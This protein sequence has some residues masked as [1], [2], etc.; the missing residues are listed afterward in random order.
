MHIYTHNAIHIY[1]I[2]IYIY[3]LHRLSSNL[4]VTTVTCALVPPPVQK[5]DGMQ[6]F[7]LFFFLFISFQNFFLF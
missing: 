2:Y 3:I 4:A 1:C 6:G 7:F 5:Q